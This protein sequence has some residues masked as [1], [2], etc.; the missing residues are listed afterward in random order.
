VSS[1]FVLVIATVVGVA[2]VALNGR[3]RNR[4]R[5]YFNQPTGAR[6]SAGQHQLAY[7][8]D[9]PTGAVPLN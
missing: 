3:L 1:D 5:A 7:G 8:S 2:L 4:R 9:G 6:P